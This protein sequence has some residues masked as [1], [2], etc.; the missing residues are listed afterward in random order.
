MPRSITLL[1]KGLSFPY[2]T[3]P[4]PLFL[5]IYLN[6][7]FKCQSHLLFQTLRR[8]DRAHRSTWSC[9]Y[10]VPRSLSPLCSL[11]YLLTLIPNV[12]KSHKLLFSRA[13]LILFITCHQFCSYKVIKNFHR[14]G[15]CYVDNWILFFTHSA[16]LYL[17]TGKFN[18]FTF[19]LVIYRK[20]P[21]MATFSLVFCLSC[22][23]FILLSCCLPL[24][25][26]FFFVVTFFD[27]LAFWW[28]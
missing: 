23:Y 21:V 26:W 4:C 9:N 3:Q 11:P 25:H 2:I 22:G 7:S 27:S 17:L 14:F 20:G 15:C 19:K 8:C 6:M 12:Q 10:H 1:L 24:F 18:Q 13:F 28:V 5:W 16:T